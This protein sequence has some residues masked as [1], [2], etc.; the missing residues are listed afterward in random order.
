MGISLQLP[1]YPVNLVHP[2]KIAEKI[3]HG[4]AQRGER[5]IARDDLSPLRG[6]SAGSAVEDQ[7]LT[8][9]GY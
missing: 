5:A 6:F 3:L 4:V 8:P 9:P 7:G 1:S 2:V